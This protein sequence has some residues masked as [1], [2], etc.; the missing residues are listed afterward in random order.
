MLHN[1]EIKCKTLKIMDFVL[2]VPRLNPA[3]DAFPGLRPSR[4]DQAKCGVRV[5][6]PRWKFNQKPLA[7]SAFT[8]GTIWPKNRHS[9][10]WPS[11][12]PETKSSALALK[13]KRWDLGMDFD[14][15]TLLVQ[16]SRHRRQPDQINAS[17]SYV[18]STSVRRR[19]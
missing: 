1:A 10:P 9:L 4:L 12:S 6:N 13:M 16:N 19:L 3:V 14:S 2:R 5:S 11:P 8:K 17:P 18:Q 15:E 7:L